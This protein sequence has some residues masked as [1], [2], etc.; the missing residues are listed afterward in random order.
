MTTL[1]KQKLQHILNEDALFQGF[2]AAEKQQ[3]YTQAKIIRY[4]DQQQIL[5]DQQQL[6]HLYILLSG[7]LQIGWVQDNGELKMNDF[8]GRYTAFNIVA[9]LQ[10][11][12][13]QFDYMTIGT[14]E[15]ALIPKQLFLE[16]VQHSAQAAW[17]ILMVLSQRMS[18]QFEQT[19]YV[20][21]A[22]LNQR[23]AKHLLQLDQQHTLQS[24]QQKHILKISQH[25]LAALFGVSRQTMNKYLAHLEKLGCVQL[26]YGQLKITDHQQLK[27]HSEL[28]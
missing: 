5:R 12:P 14:V 28:D 21:T 23:I 11:K 10:N 24:Y 26:S 27:R 1:A 7:K 19:R 15:L 6:D 17:G 4:F 18:R 9:L 2:S 25:E 22:N 13:V 3:L 20:H 16:S 8:L